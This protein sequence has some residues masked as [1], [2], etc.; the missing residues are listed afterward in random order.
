MLPELW[1]SVSDDRVCDPESDER[2]SVAVADSSSVAVTDKEP[3]LLAPR[4][5]VIVEKLLGFRLVPSSRIRKYAPS[6]KLVL[7]VALDQWTVPLG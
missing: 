1:L 3:T 5:V 6:V 4:L 2:R 7:P